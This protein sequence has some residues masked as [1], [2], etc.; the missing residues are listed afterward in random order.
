[1]RSAMD[2]YGHSQTSGCGNEWVM[3][4]TPSADGSVEGVAGGSQMRFS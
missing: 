1:M 3:G 4:E 2:M